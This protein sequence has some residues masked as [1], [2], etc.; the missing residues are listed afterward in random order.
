MGGCT[1]CCTTVKLYKVDNNSSYF[2]NLSYSTD[3][4]HSQ[5][6]E[7]QLQYTSLLC[8]HERPGRFFFCFFLIIFLFFFSCSIWR[9]G[10]FIFIFFICC[11]FY[12]FCFY[13]LT[14]LFL[15]YVAYK[16]G[17]HQV[18]RRV[19]VAL[20]M[21]LDQSDLSIDPSESHGHH[22]GKTTMEP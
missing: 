22:H 16:I 17:T 18:T 20:S 21:L 2:G 1:L 12:C 7:A 3:K 9:Q 15:V 6:P 11:A 5:G 8:I 10:F 4:I 19:P 13:L 14:Y